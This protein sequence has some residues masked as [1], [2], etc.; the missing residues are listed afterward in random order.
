MPSVQSD[1]EHPVPTSRRGLIY[2]FTPKHHGGN[3]SASCWLTELTFDEEFAIFDR[4]DEHQVEDSA[5][6]L[7]GYQVLEASNRHLRDLGSW[8]QQMAE[9]PVQRPGSPWHGYPIWPI[10]SMAPPQYQGQRCRPERQV[11]DR[12][13]ELGDITIGQRKRLKKGE[14]I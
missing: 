9:Y 2:L 13:V 8:S 5:G 3:A 4:A 12:M 7:Y 14:F 1:T 6:N 11:F 10:A